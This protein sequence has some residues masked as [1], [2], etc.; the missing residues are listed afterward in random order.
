[1]KTPRKKPHPS[2]FMEE[3]IVVLGLSFYENVKHYLIF[4]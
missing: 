4:C 3:G 1:M 2:L